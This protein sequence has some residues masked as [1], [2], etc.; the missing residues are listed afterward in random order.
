[1]K[2]TPSTPRRRSGK[3]MAL[4]GG[5]VAALAAA[6]W[7]GWQHYHAQEDALSRYL[8]A[9]VQQGDI[10][11]LVTATGSLQPSDYVDVGA[12]VSGQLE[13]IYAEVGSVVKK[14]DLLAE[15]DSTVYRATVDARRAAL[16]NLQATL[17]ARQSDL[18]LAEQQL[19]RQQ[20][21][22]RDSATSEESL[23][24]SQA[25]LR[26][27]RAQVASVQAQI[28]QAES[29]LRVDETSLKYSQILAPMDGVVV[30]ISL[31]QGQTINASQSSPTLLRIAD[32]STMTVQTQVSEA[33]V[34]RLRPG[35]PVYFTTLGSRNR[36]YQGELRKVEPTPT[37]NNNVVLYNALFDVKNQQRN[38]LPQMTAQ[39]FFVAAEA[40]DTLVVPAGAVKMARMAPGSRRGQPEASGAAGEPPRGEASAGK[41]QQP[42]AAGAPGKE[43]KTAANHQEAK[44]QALPA[45]AAMGAAGMPP[46][47]AVGERPAGF[48][49]APLSDAEREARRKQFESMTPQQREA[50]RA[51]GA[52]QRQAQGEGAMA[53]A[54]PRGAAAMPADTASAGKTDKAGK[55]AANPAAET[56][57]VK[58]RA[59]PVWSG[60]GS[61]G[62]QQRVREGTVRVVLPD[63]SIVERKV[64]VGITDRVNYQV[65]AGLKPGERVIVGEKAQDKEAA[66]GN[67]RNADMGPPPGAGMASPMG[68]STGARSR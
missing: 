20:N 55:A 66:R 51:R 36:R 29:T 25:S 50:W 45:N 7:Y 53:P 1:M 22:A 10:E 39:V 31:K 37:V 35:M 24:Q 56:A 42:A 18:Q 58:P 5:I 26:S 16:K 60:V 11:D 34:T 52:E 62:R 2:P 9:S 30:S 61:G 21:L 65:I 12:Q 27:A 13:K 57:R 33:D 46:R 3:R 67:N 14:G 49:G 6:G 43:G 59:L 47:A 32:L 64:T 8:I 28:E 44:R 63:N 23:Q 68:G 15:I 17:L 48:G 54:G 38:L 41:G 19:Q 40:H 4:A